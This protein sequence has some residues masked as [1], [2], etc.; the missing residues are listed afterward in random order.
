[1]F[2]TIKKISLEAKE[3]KKTIVAE[4]LKFSSTKAKMVS[5]YSKSGKKYNRMLSSFE[6]SRFIN[7]LISRCHKDGVRLIF[8]DPRNTTKIG[9]QKFAKQRSLNGHHAAALVIARRGSSFKDKLAV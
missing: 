2:K 1:M 6:Y 9:K 5:A 7:A 3:K 4:K 8:V